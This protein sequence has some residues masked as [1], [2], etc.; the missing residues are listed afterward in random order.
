LLQYSLLYAVLGLFV[1][2]VATLVA[3]SIISAS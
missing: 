3:V 2:M 1:T